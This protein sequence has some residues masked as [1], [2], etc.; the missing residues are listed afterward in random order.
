MLRNTL[1][2][3]LLCPLLIAGCTDE[4]MP[5]GDGIDAVD[6][7]LSE[8]EAAD[9]EPADARPIPTVPGLGSNDCIGDSCV[10]ATTCAPVENERGMFM[11]EEWILDSVSPSATVLTDELVGF[12]V[13]HGVTRIYFQAQGHLPTA[14]GRTKLAALIAAADQHC[15]GVDLLLG[16]HSWHL[17][18]QTGAQN[19]LSNAYELV[20]GLGATARPVRVQFDV[21]PHANSTWNS[22]NNAQ[23]T[24]ALGQLITLYQALQTLGGQLAAQY[25][26][27]ISAPLE[28]VGVAPYWYDEKVYS[29]AVPVG[30]VTRPMIEWM[31]DTLD[32]VNLMDYRDTY[33][34]FRSKARNEVTYAQASGGKIVAG[35]ETM[36]GLS[37]SSTFCEEGEQG[38]PAKP[39]IYPVLQLANDYFGAA[40]PDAWSGVFIHHAVSWMPLSPCDVVEN[41]CASGQT[42]QTSQIMAAYA[43][44][45]GLP[46]LGWAVCV[47]EATPS[48]G[49][50]V[51]QGSEAC[52]DGNT[53]DTDRCSNTC[54]I[55][56]CPTGGDVKGM[57]VWNDYVNLVNNSADA[58]ELLDFAR[59]KNVTRL[60]FDLWDEEAGALLTASTPGRGLLADFIADADARCVEVDLLV[61]PKTDTAYPAMEGWMDPSGNV[62]TAIAFA[63]DAVEF[64][65]AL[66]GPKPVGIHL[67][68][69]PAHA[70]DKGS[71]MPGVVAR[72]ID[73]LYAIT[74]AFAAA[75]AQ[76]GTTL[77]INADANVWLQHH[78][79]TRGGATKA[80]HIWLL[81]RLDATFMD[82]VDNSASLIDYISTEMTYAAGL[83]DRQVIVG[84]E[85]MCGLDDGD[86]FCEEGEAAMSSALASVTSAYSANPTWQGVAIHYYDSYAELGN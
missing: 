43:T 56:A 66:T 17:P 64:T 61:G 31:S 37:A 8:I 34:S 41:D 5:D 38:T 53:D 3:S 50:G 15:I 45:K 1:T 68:I 77:R 29:T 72:L 21:E 57:W 33:T 40:A 82:Y 32:V 71:N 49:D 30:G 52:D 11:W 13:S 24:V 60:I 78:N 69:E 27:Q 76:D 26:G 12:A 19:L 75:Q 59:S 4:D 85:T 74:D 28:I 81:D 44:R 83:T 10:Q 62:A 80:A 25:A 7:D 48:C 79:I 55:Q 84:V 9:G 18:G 42:C 46:Q 65:A 70:P 22:K 6:D 47:G 58:G 63:E 73:R 86:T 20:A 39:G 35:V 2:F 54:T 67:D 16:D 36:C 23:K 51:V 14:G